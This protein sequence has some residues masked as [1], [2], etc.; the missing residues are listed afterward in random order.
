MVHFHFEYKHGITFSSHIKSERT[1]GEIRNNPVIYTRFFN[2]NNINLNWKQTNSKLQKQEKD[3][4]KCPLSNSIKK[5][6]EKSCK[7]NIEITQKGS[8]IQMNSGRYTYLTK[9]NQ[10]ESIN[11]LK[12]GNEKIKRQLFLSTI[13]AVS[14]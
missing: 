7:K 10:K 9:Q 1:N 4:K 8:S 14:T 3:Y 5:P 11:L 6:W 2:N 12:H 13:R